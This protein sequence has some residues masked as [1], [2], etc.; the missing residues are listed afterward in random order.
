MDKYIVWTD[1]SYKSS[2]DAGGYSS[3]ITIDEKIITKL[4]Q[5][6]KSTTNNRME[7]MGVLETLKYFNTPTNL[8]IYS[9]S[10]YVVSSINN[11]HV[12]KWF[13]NN[14]LTKKN[15]D[16]WFE[17]VNL[18][19]I[20]N[21]TFEWVKGHNKNKWNEL[22]DLYAQHAAECINL[23]IDKGYKNNIYYDN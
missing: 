7:L 1:G 15:L 23:P 4:Y 11:N 5:G 14:D 8:H 20:H 12:Y 19:E 18:L 17:I 9:D 22:A 3:I 10:Q 13:E 16:L 6:F 21:V 2:I